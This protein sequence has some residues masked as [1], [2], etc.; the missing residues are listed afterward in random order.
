MS[1]IV[2]ADGLVELDGLIYEIGI[3]TPFSIKPLSS[4]WPFL[5]AGNSYSRQRQTDSSKIK[6][7]YEWKVQQEVAIIS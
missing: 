1:S 3:S 4:P 7:V 2:G 5:L 6:T